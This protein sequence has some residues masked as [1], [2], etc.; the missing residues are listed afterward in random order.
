MC[1]RGNYSVEELIKY[2]A[3]LPLSRDMSLLIEIKQHLPQTSFAVL[4]VSVTVE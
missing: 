1:N 4:F 2:P 3:K